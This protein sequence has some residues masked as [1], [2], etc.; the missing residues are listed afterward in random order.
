MEVSDI[1]R[2]LT[3]DI[4]PQDTLVQDVVSRFPCGFVALPDLLSDLCS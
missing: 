2:L 4:S 1:G 3:A